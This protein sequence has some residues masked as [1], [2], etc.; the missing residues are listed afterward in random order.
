MRR[1]L[2]ILC[3][4][5][6]VLQ[7]LSGA[8]IT[9]VQDPSLG[10]QQVRPHNIAVA[11]NN[12]FF[13]A[14]EDLIGSGGTGNIVGWFYNPATST[15]TEVQD[16]SLG[17]QRA[18]PFNVV[19]AENNTFF[20]VNNGLIGSGGTSSIVGWFY[21]PAT[22]LSTA[23]QVQDPSLG[24]QRAG[25]VNVVAENNTFFITNDGVI[26]SGGTGSIVGWFYNPATSISTATQVQDPSLGTQRAQPL[27]VA[28]AGNNTFFIANSGFIGSGGTGSIVGW[29]YNPAT[30]ISTATQIQ[31]P[32]LGTQQAHPL[33]IA[34]A[35]NNTF[36][37]TNTEAIGS[38][39]FGSIVGW[40]YDGTTLTEVQDPSLGTQRAF[41]LNV[42]A[43][44]N[45]TFFIENSGFIGSGG[46][47]NIVGWFYNPATSISTAP[48]VQDP[49]LGTQ[50]CHPSNIAAAGNNTFFITN[51]EFIGSG[52]FG[53]V[54]GWFYNPAT[55]TLIELQDPSLGT[56]RAIPANVVAAGNN[57]FFIANGDLIG[58]GGFG[59]IVGWFYNPATSTFIELQDPS[60]GTQQANPFNVAVAGDNTFF[61]VNTDTIGSG[62]FGSIVGW[63]YNPAT[64]ISTVTQVQDPSLGTQQGLPVNLA[65]AG[66]TFFIVN[67]SNLGSGGVGDIV[68]WY[69]IPTFPPSAIQ[70]SSRRNRFLTQT[71]HFNQIQW[72]APS[73]ITPSG[74]MI[75]RDAALTDRIATLPN[76]VFEYLDHNRMHKHIYSY[77]VVAVQNGSLSSPIE[78]IIYV[79]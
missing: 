44:G 73:G 74:Y 47:S 38:G 12:T 79:P 18:A 10:T 54:V 6:A 63:F 50:L 57:T 26:G 33:N 72:T 9:E 3:G 1:V 55:S 21:N 5:L 68:G 41:A 4:C 8:T 56:Q 31:D 22:S 49:S 11:G 76:N 60:L 43:A 35:G 37:I 48:E 70:G 77:F 46:T 15:L 69:F 13:I 75:F 42:A 36:F 28:A 32:S 14:N 23:T 67:D 27:N 25:P 2:W 19:A 24:T 61:I 53:S 39:G 64:S 66:N 7:V 71:D 40:F 34:A 62:G 58:S 59:S 17:T 30:S 45:N 51:N 29:F 52:G 78:I 16:P 20:I 65:T